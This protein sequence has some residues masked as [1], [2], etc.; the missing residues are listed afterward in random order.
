MKNWRENDEVRSSGDKNQA[1]D[2]DVSCDWKELEAADDNDNDDN[3]SNGVDNNDD[4]F[5]NDDD[6]NDDNNDVDND[7]DFFR[8]GHISFENKT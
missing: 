7:A 5:G 3:T 4:A 8:L 6:N 2:F 1:I